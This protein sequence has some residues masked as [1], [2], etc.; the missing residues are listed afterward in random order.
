MN[1]AILV[2]AD[3]WEGLFINGKL[4][5]EGHTLNEGTSRI[6]YFLKLAKEHNFDLEEMKEVYVND[7][8]E[9]WLN[10]YGFPD[11]LSTLSGDYENYK[12]E[13]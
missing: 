12:D 5:K 8:D 2:K 9:E 11:D 10:D 4:T 13:D 3:D 7:E 1:K 6:K